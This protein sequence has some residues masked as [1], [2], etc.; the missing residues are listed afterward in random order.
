MST[1]N[2]FLAHNTVFQYD[3]DGVPTFVSV[4]GIRNISGPNPSVGDK[5]VTTHDSDGKREFVPGT[6]DPGEVSLD[7]VWDPD[8]AAGQ[9]WLESQL[10]VRNKLFK[11]IYPSTDSQEYTF[12]G[13]VKS[14]SQEAPEDDELVRTVTIK[15]SGAITKV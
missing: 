13:Y 11:I 9:A 15:L 4:E 14:L 2:K 3:S 10:G 8:S 6:I 1:T 12:N 7:L 5:D